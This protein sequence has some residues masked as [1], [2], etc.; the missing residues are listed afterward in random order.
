MKRH[1]GGKPQ[2]FPVN[3]FCPKCHVS[4]SLILSISI[5]SCLLPKWFWGPETSEEGGLSVGK[6][7]WSVQKAE[8]CQ[9]K[10]LLCSLPT[11]PL[12]PFWVS[13]WEL[14]L[15]KHFPLYFSAQRRTARLALGVFFG[16]NSG[17]TSHGHEQRLGSES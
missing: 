6:R 5:A 13:T 3:L 16:N 8:G 7:R 11:T 1:L 4:V 2:R 15:R 10:S 12:S 14:G 9:P 17:G